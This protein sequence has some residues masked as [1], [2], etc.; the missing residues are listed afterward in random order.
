MYMKKMA[1][2]P[3]AKGRIDLRRPV[4]ENL[5]AIANAFGRQVGDITAIVLERPRH[6][7]LVA[8]IRDAG[9]ASS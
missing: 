9:R 6:D 1:V 3:V 4:G 7:D 2:G 5:V 8:E